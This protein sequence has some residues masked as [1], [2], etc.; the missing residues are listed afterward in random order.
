MRLESWRAAHDHA[1]HLAKAIMG[2]E[3]TYD[4]VPWFWSDQYDLTLQVA[5]LPEPGHAEVTRAVEGGLIL[6]Q[7]AADGTLVSA[8]GAG[9]SNAVAK[10]IRL[11]EMMIARGTKPDPAALAD[12]STN[13]KALL[14]G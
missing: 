7:I 8:A 10:D 3:E 11:A 6:F 12:P 14:K 13:L 9:P 4:A 2:A 5:G 1:N